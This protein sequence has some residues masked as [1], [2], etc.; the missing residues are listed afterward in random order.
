MI[1]VFL[2]TFTDREIVNPSEE[3][4]RDAHILG[5]DEGFAAGRI[6]KA[7]ED[8]ENYQQLHIRILEAINQHHEIAERV[9]QFTIKSM[10]ASIRDLLQDLAPKSIRAGL[11]DSLNNIL[12]SN[13]KIGIKTIIKVGRNILDPRRAEEISKNFNIILKISDEI[14]ENEVRIEYEATEKFINIDEIKIAFEGLIENHLGL[15]EK[16]IQ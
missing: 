6:S 13:D 4:M 10:N 11:L 7:A 2:E 16:K 3:L 1:S 5:F 15:E 9:K 12:H 8:S 14:P